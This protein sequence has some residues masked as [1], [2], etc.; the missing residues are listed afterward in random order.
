MFSI[1]ETYLKNLYWQASGN[2][3][4]Q[5]INIFSLPLIT[6]LFAPESM[7]LLGLALQYIS[8][9][10]ILISLRFEH[11]VVWPKENHDAQHLTRFVLKFGALSCL[12]WTFLCAIATTTFL[13]DSKL[14]IWLLLLPMTA[15]MLVCAQALQQLDQR[16]SSFKL[17]GMSEL[18]N[19]CVNNGF[20][21]I[22]GLFSF[23]GICLLLGVVLGQ[24]AKILVFRRHFGLLRGLFF[25]D[26][27]NAIRAAKCLKLFKLNGSLMLSHLMLSLTAVIPLTYIAFEW[28]KAEV[29][30]FSLVLSTLA[31][32]TALFGNA[33]GQVFYQ[34]SSKQFAQNKS[35]D[36]LLLSNLKLLMV[37]GIP[38]FSFVCFFGPDIYALVFGAPWAEAGKIA[39]YY[40]VA[41][42]L[43]FFTTPFDRSGIIVNAWWYGP[44]W[45]LSRLITTAIVLVVAW[46]FE[47][48]F[49][50][51]M[52]ILTL[53]ISLMYTI[54]GIASFMFSRRNQAFS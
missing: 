45:H 3:L 9:L 17:S 37:M 12:L 47:L 19:R 25:Q 4:A 27:F 50:H 36:R 22:G 28:G 23:G 14:H 11:L 34:Q 51:F 20:V 21:V 49:L 30:H 15:Y 35:F 43:S 2:S 8:L 13:V 18:V 53:Q 48:S 40:S 26:I 16:S 29:G 5:L 39:S 54:D 10:T 31:L 38:C 24:A 41:A 46:F 42:A 1:P 6:R 7:G 33:M 32:P 52:Y 44:A